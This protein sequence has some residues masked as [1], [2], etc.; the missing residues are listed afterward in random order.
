MRC[1]IILSLF[2][3]FLFEKNTYSQITAQDAVFLN[4]QLSYNGIVVEQKPG[5]YIRLLRLP[6]HDTLQFSM[7]SIDRIVKI[8]D[9]KPAAENPP[10][11]TEPLKKFNQN[12]HQVMVHAYAGGGDY[13]L[14]GFGISVNRNFSD[15]WQLG[16][17]AHYIGQNGSYNATYPEQQIVP[18]TV[19]ARYK[20]TQTP[21]GRFATLLSLSTGYNFMLKKSYFD[22]DQ[23]IN[24]N[25]RNGL[26][27]NPSIAFRANLLP[28]AGLMFDVGYQ[29]TTSTLFDAQNNEKITKKQWRNFAIR[30][31]LFF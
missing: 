24:I 6:E 17:G 26:F 13:S 19:D 9:T 4:N 29:L 14:G 30:G 1:S 12:K 8:F 25:V 15:R 3:V 22:P 10:A 5:E 2:C 31:T 11:T 18:V 21:S 7:D 16:L 23:N 27:F 20:F 28:N